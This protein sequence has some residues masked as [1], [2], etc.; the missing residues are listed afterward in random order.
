MLVCDGPTQTLAYVLVMSHCHQEV[1]VAHLFASAMFQCCHLITRTYLFTPV[2]G[3]S[4]TH[5]VTPLAL[6]L[7][8]LLH[9]T[10]TIL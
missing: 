4:A 10:A 3:P 5:P 1:A 8:H 2:L 7:A 6:Q 9:P